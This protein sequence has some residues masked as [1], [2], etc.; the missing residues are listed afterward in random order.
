MIQVAE[1]GGAG[2]LFIASLRLLDG[3][4]KNINGAERM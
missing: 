4:G 3:C 2:C 1:S